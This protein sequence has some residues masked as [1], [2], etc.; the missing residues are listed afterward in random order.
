MNFYFVVLCGILHFIHSVEFPKLKQGFKCDSNDKKNFTIV[1][2]KNYTKVFKG[3]GNAILYVISEWCDYCCQQEKV[4]LD[5][6]EKIKMSKD[7]AIKGI[8]IYTLYSDKDMNVLIK[9]RIGFFKVPSVYL[10]HNS[11]YYQYG[12]HFT[13]DSI[14][15]FMHKI[16]NPIHTYNSSSIEDIEEFFND[17]TTVIKILGLF[18]NKKEYKEELINFRK[19]AFLIKYRNDVSIGFSTNQTQIAL[20]KAKYDG[21]WF[22]YHSYNTIVLKRYDTFY[23]LDLSL[24]S[25][26]IFSFVYYNTF[27]PLDELS[28]NNNNFLKQ[29]KTPLALF[30]IDSTY[31]LNNFE[32]I[33]QYITELSKDYDTKYVFMYMDGNARSKTK[34]NFGLDKT[35][36]I[37]TLVIHYLTDNKIFKFN[38]EKEFNDKNIRNFLNEHLS[39][40]NINAGDL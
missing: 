16:I 5:L 25:K 31:N 4:L 21:K 15:R 14:L 23:H 37:P 9:E 12:Y 29:L 33:Y 18:T 2:A 27:S 10:Y 17:N 6:E 22:D 39:I 32:N 1:T 26:D 19:Y 34:E 40:T 38:H 11:R 35:A 24:H 36:N 7:K 13:S 20:I 30:F 8:K 28:N 3:K